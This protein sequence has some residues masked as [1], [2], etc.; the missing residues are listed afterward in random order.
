MSTRHERL[1]DTPTADRFAAAYR[2]RLV[3]GDVVPVIVDRRTMPDECGAR[4]EESEDGHDKAYLEQVVCRPRRLAPCV[5]IER[6]CRWLPPAETEGGGA[7]GR[8]AGA[9][10]M[11]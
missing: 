1:I 10:E 8:F 4:G 6:A 11:L 2:A 5:G 7:T 3:L 9:L